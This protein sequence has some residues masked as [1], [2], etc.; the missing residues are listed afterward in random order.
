MFGFL[1]PAGCDINLTVTDTTQYVAT[2]G[3]PLGYMDN[4]DCDF[5]FVAPP[6]R[7]FIVMFEDFRLQEEYD[8]ENDDDYYSYFNSEPIR[9]YLHFRKFNSHKH[10]QT[11]THTSIT[12]TINQQADVK[13]C[14]LHQ[15]ACKGISKKAWYLSI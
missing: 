13:L 11:H 8:D 2:E 10:R 6:G 7:K 12:M 5:N 4:Q 15:Y 9:D 1:D 3:Y 14:C